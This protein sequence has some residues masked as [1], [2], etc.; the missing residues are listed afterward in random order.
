M[1]A[2]ATKVP[3]LELSKEECDKLSMAANNVARHYNLGMTEKQM[4]WAH[5]FMA[6][7]TVYGTRV[8]IISNRKKLE[9]AMNVQGQQNGFGNTA[10]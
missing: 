6:L 10:L 5:L 4:D 7:G 1:L 9:K 3:E 8:W 2:A